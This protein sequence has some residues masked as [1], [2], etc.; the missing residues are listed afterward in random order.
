MILPNPEFSLT[1]PLCRKG[2]QTHANRKLGNGDNHK[3]SRDRNVLHGHGVYPVT[4]FKNQLGVVKKPVK[5]Y[6]AVNTTCARRV[7]TM[8]VRV[9]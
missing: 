3:P 5:P 8:I 9:E 7:Q 2:C 1:S 6:L 4:M